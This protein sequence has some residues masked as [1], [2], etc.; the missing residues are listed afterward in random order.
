MNQITIQLT[1][2]GRTLV[3]WLIALN[4]LYT[5]FSNY[6]ALESNKSQLKIM[7]KAIIEEKI[8]FH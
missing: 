7:T 3:I 5:L 2:H 4:S 6:F 1:Y 8:L